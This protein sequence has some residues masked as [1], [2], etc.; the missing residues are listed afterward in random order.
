[1]IFLILLRSSFFLKVREAKRRGKKKREFV[2]MLASIVTS[3]S[4]KIIHVGESLGWGG[5]VG[6]VEVRGREENG[7]GA[8]LRVLPRDR[9][10]LLRASKFNQLGGARGGSGGGKTFEAGTGRGAAAA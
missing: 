7:L 2:A 8:L 9:A 10:G 1:M 3:V 4:N 5:G 6:S